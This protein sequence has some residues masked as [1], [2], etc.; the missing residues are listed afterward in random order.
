MRS[1]ILAFVLGWRH[2]GFSLWAAEE[3]ESGRLVGRIGLIR[4]HDWPVD[5]RSR[6]AGRSTSTSGDEGWPRRA[7]ERRSPAGGTIRMIH[8]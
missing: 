6:S 3:L 1:Q 5:P 4:H 7:D 2:E 8:G